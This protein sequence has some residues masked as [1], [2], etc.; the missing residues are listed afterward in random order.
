MNDFAQE[1]INANKEVFQANDAR[2]GGCKIHFEKN[3]KSRAT[4]SIKEKVIDDV[5]TIVNAISKEDAYFLAELIPKEWNE[6]LDSDLSS[7]GKYLCKQWTDKN[8][9]Y[10]FC[11]AEAGLCDDKN[12]L[13]GWHKAFKYSFLEK[14]R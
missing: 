13:E 3:V 11:F 9:N 6:S 14:K 10:F 4:K 1:I 8:F 12:I 2:Q 7:M 5:E